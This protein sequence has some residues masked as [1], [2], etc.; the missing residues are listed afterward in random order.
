M[1]DLTQFEIKTKDGLKVLGEF[2]GNE[3]SGNI[4]VFSHGFGLQRDNRGKFSELSKV[5]KERYIVVKFDYN[6]VVNDGSLLVPIFSDQVEILKAILDYVRKKFPN[7][8]VNVIA[9]SL[10]CVILGHLNPDGLS[11]VILSAP[12]IKASGADFL[13]N[14]SYRFE[15]TN[16]HGANVKI[17]RSDGSYTFLRNGFVQS[18]ENNKP[19]ESYLNLSL[20][21]KIS[22][23]IATQDSQLDYKDYSQML[24]ELPFNIVKIKADH[25]FG[26][27]ARKVWIKIVKN[28]LEL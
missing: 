21:C 4:I 11:N 6:K 26:G 15:Q 3:E 8:K 10:G 24:K 5:L 16:Q 25:D 13:N 9:H 18:L 1:V 28:L 19:Y 27:K 2:E 17:K 12:P 22:A 14:F 7:S 23:I 20:K